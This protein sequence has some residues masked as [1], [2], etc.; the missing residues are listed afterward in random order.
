MSKF[1]Q[2]LSIDNYCDSGTEKKPKDLNR[3]VK[4]FNFKMIDRYLREK[5][6]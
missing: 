2:I 3:D 5:L 6:K 4:W 1:L